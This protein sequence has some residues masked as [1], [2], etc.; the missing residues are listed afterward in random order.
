MHSNLNIHYNIGRAYHTDI[1]DNAL[2]IPNLIPFVV[3]IGN[4][5]EGEHWHIDLHAV[6]QSRSLTQLR[7]SSNDVTLEKFSAQINS[8]DFDVFTNSRWFTNLG[9]GYHLP[10]NWSLQAN[11]SGFIQPDYQYIGQ[12]NRPYIN[13]TFPYDLSLSIRYGVFN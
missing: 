12:A 7:Y 13:Q 4:S 10:R 5:Y 8:A 2:A 11:Y 6:W 1:R 3:S 9:I